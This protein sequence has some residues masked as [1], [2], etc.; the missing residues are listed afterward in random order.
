VQHE[1][2]RGPA[3]VAFLGTQALGDFLV[4]HLIAA[5]IARAFAG[6]RLAV[7]Y[8]DDRPYKNFLTR[9]NPYVTTSLNLPAKGD[10]AFPLDWFDGRE[11]VPGRP[12]GSSWYENGFHQPDLFLT[13]SILGPH[14]GTSVGPPPIFRVPDDTVTPLGQALKGYGLDENRW[15][16]CL[17]MREQFYYWRHNIDRSRSVDPLS[18]VPMIEHIVRNQGGQVVRV[19]DPSMAPLPPMEGLIDLSADPDSFAAEVFAASRARYYIGTE[20]GPVAL[21]CAFKVPAAYTNCCGA[22][23]WND[24]DVV[25]PRRNIRTPGKFELTGRQM[26]ELMEGV[27]ML[28]GAT[29]MEGLRKWI[30]STEMDANTPDELIAVADHMYRVTNGCEGWRGDPPVDTLPAAKSVTFPLALCELAKTYD[31]AWM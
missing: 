22:G 5:S 17:H 10:F 20:S 29:E 21:A 25:L 19:G 12:F 23:V 14:I 15:F 6:S 8:R 1:A 7:I 26:S 4:Y 24:G 27:G 16:A 31:I 18:Y 11:N 30:G 28:M 13:P 9:I 2:K 3:I